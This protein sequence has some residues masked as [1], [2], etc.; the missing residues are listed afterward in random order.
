MRCFHCILGLVV[1]MAVCGCNADP[2]GDAADA[3][4]DAGDA[5]AAE[6]PSVALPVDTDGDGLCDRTERQFGT[7]DQARDTDADEL[8]DLIEIGN[9]FDATSP[10]EPAEDQIGHLVGEPGSVLEFPVRMTVQGDGQALS[11]YFEV[12]PSI[13]ADGLTAQDFFRGTMATSAD[14]VDGVRSVQPGSARF[15][16]VLGR[17]RLSFALRF[18]Y[19]QDAAVVECGRAYPL[20]YALKSDDGMTVAERIFLL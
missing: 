5:G 2:N 10:D 13:Y 15:A 6:P 16:G 18:E 19:P 17:T 20:R 14:P 3:G 1:L 7:D 8:P 12:I 9:G 11:G 4:P